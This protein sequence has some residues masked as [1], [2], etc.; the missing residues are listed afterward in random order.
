[1]KKYLIVIMIAL[2]LAVIITFVLKSFG[3]ENVPGITGGIVGVIV[4]AI[5]FKFFSKE[6]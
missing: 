3:I 4:G 5:S 2:G 1:M 6:K